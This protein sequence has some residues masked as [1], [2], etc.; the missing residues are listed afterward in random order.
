MPEESLRGRAGSCQIFP[1]ANGPARASLLVAL[2]LT[3]LDKSTY[4][5]GEQIEYEMV[6]LSGLVEAFVVA[7]GRAF[8]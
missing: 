3:A 8:R 6:I 1:S 4:A 7:S 5:L 2:T